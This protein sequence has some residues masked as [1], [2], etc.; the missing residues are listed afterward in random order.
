MDYSVDDFN[1]DFPSDAA[2]LDQLVA[3]I[4]PGGITCRSCGVTR[5]HHRLNSRRALSCDYC[6]THV[7]PLAGTMFGKSSTSLRC[8]FYAMYLVVSTGG[9]LSE[10]ELQRELGVAQKTAGRMLQQIASLFPAQATAGSTLAPAT[11]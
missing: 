6:G 4:Y 3:M 11:I 8:W 7:Y 2:C 9:E 10:K 5:K 1:R